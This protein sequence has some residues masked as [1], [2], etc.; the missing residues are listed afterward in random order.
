MPVLSRYMI[1]IAF[2]N[3]WL[4]FGL[5][6]LLM[7]RKAR[8]DMLDSSVATWI[9]AHVD[10]LLVGWMVQ[11]SMGVAY[12]ILPHLPNTLTERGRYPFALSA[13]VLVNAGVWGYTMGII[14][15]VGLA[16]V[17]GLICQFAGVLA[18]A[19]HIA[20]R[21]CLSIVK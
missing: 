13:V 19:V 3:L 4:G 5:A 9:L 11:L 18:F 8:P 6:T 14:G 12:W 10:L 16:E 20:P 15:D 1:R 2:L 21:V 7:V 17:L